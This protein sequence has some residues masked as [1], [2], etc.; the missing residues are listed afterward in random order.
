MLES[1][2]VKFKK[3]GFARKKKKKLLDLN[4][5]WVVLKSQ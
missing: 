3:G 2:G 4:F 5:A 1:I